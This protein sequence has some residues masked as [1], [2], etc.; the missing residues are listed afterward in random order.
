MADYADELRKLAAILDEVKRE[1]NLAREQ[2]TRSNHLHNRAWRTAVQAAR[3][4]ADA[5]DLGFFEIWPRGPWVLSGMRNPDDPDRTPLTIQFGEWKGQVV[6]MKYGSGCNPDGTLRDDT[7][8][9]VWTQEICPVMRSTKTASKAD[10]GAYD[11]PRLKTDDQGKIL[12]QDGMPL[13]VVETTDPKTG[14]LTGEEID[15][16]AATVVD[17]Y[18]EA[19]A[20][21]HLRCQA[22]DWVDACDVA[23][24]L[25]RKE[26]GAN[27]PI[28]EQ[29]EPCAALRDDEAEAKSDGPIP[30]AETESGSVLLFDRHDKPVV[31]GNEKPTLTNAQYDVVLALLQTGDKGLTKD[32]LDRESRRGDARKIIKRLSDGDSDWQS[33]ISFPGTPG[34]GYRII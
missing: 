33:V 13:E 30:I 25:I 19:D 10:A 8:F 11:F 14:E 26:A 27:Q 7:A 29:S 34:K 20:L 21:A 6:S 1:L 22:A 3:A 15:G 2:D 23:A 28:G 16:P 17:D 24:D 32:E 18:D 12:G 31:N 5:V 4:V 9:A